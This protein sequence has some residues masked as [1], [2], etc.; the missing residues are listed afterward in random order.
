VLHINALLGFIPIVRTKELN[1][2]TMQFEIELQQWSGR[3][4]R[5]VKH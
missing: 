3:E 1:S 5:I 4:S 2:T